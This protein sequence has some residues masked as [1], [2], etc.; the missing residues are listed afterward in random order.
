MTGKEREF[1]DLWQSLDERE[2][3]LT[4]AYMR[5]ITGKNIKPFFNIKTAAGVL[6]VTERTALEYIRTGKLTAH[7]AA[8]RWIIYKDDLEAFIDGR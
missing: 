2:R 7:K 4:L 1:I 3:D 5:D 6:K 8:G